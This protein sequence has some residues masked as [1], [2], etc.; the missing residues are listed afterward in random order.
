MTAYAGTDPY[1]LKDKG[2]LVCDGSVLSRA[3]Y[4]E[5][6]Q[7]I[8]A[9][10]GA[11]NQNSFN[12]ADCRGYFV[13]GVDRGGRRDPSIDNRTAPR[14]GANSGDRAGSIQAPATQMPTE[15][16]SADI[17][18][19]PNSDYHRAYSG[20][21]LV[22]SSYNSGSVT[23]KT[24]GGGDAE[25]RPKNKYVYYIVKAQ[26]VANG[27]EVT[28]PVGSVTPFAGSLD[29]NVPSGYLLCDG[30]SLDSTNTYS[31]LFAAIQIAH[32]GNGQPNFNIPDY[33]GFFLRGVSMGQLSDPD[34]NSRPAPFPDRPPDTAGNVGDNVGSQQGYATALPVKPF[35]T[36]FPNLPTGNFTSDNTLGRDSTRFNDGSITVNVSQS[37]GDEETRPI[38]VAVYWLIK[39]R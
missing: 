17:P 14:Y 38:N 19:L 10:N 31:D 5:L 6:F 23:V 21:N 26:S 37:G 18:H 33:R 9:A 30:A 25:T 34:R 1:G 3:D 15:S 32:G 20:S 16:F 12:L 28:L 39:F 7:A 4:P 24:S 2:W 11:P 13:R 29:S 36:S 35:E 27:E 8:G 22:I